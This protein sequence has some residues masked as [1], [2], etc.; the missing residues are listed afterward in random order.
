MNTATQA[1]QLSSCRC[2][3]FGEVVIEPNERLEYRMPPAC[4]LESFFVAPTALNFL[5]DDWVVDAVNRDLWFGAAG[6]GLRSVI[7]I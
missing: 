6:N 2:G 7:E 4:A 5:K 3:I 1:T